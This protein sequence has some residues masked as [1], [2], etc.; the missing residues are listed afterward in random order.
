MAPANLQ[1]YQIYEVYKKT[2]T[3]TDPDAPLETASSSSK[4]HNKIGYISDIL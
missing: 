2:V 3:G 1:A 4:I